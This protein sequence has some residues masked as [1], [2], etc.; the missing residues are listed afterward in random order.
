MEI[1]E[2]RLWEAET[3]GP[4]LDPNATAQTIGDW[5]E[6]FHLRRQTD[7]IPKGLPDP[8]PMTHEHTFDRPGKSATDELHLYY[9]N[10]SKCA[11]DDVGNYGV[12]VILPDGVEAG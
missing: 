1:Y 5:T 7:W 4:I 9:I 8:F 3:A 6:R 2:Q 10:G 11:I 12:I